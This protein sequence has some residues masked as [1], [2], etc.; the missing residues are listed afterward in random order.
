[1]KS[2]PKNLKQKF[3]QIQIKNSRIK[4]IKLIHFLLVSTL[5]IR[6]AFIHHV[7]ADQYIAYMEKKETKLVFKKA[8]P[9][10]SIY[11]RNQQ[12]LVVNTPITTI[13]YRYNPQIDINQM[14][15]TADLL[16]EL[17]D[18]DTQKLTNRDLDDIYRR[19]FELSD[20]IE[21]TT[22]QRESIPD[23]AKQAFMIFR[24]MSEAY[25]GGENTLK[26]D[27]TDHE[28]ARVTE[29]IDLL[30]GIDIVTSTQRDYPSVLGHHDLLGRL[31]KE[32]GLPTE[33]F[34]TYMLNNYAIN[35]RV[36]TSSLE[37]HYEELLR[38]HKSVHTQNDSHQG[39]ETLFEGYSGANLTLTIDAAFVNQVDEILERRMRS[40]KNNRPGA[41]YLNEGYVVVTNP[42]TGEILSLNGLVLEEDGTATKHPL[43]TMHNSFTMGSVIKGATMLT[44]YEH[45]VVNY[46]D[47]VHDKPMIFSDGSK[48]GSWSSLGLINDIDALRYSSNVYFMTQAIQLGGDVYYPRSHLNLDLA[49]FD[50]YRASFAQFGLGSPTGIDLPNEQ[51]GLRDSDRSVAKLLD[52]VIGQSDTYTTLQLAQYVS[53]V[54]NGGHRYALQLLKEASIPVSPYES[55]LVHSFEPKLLNTIDLPEDAFR[56]V[57]EGFRQALQMQGGTGNHVFNNASYNPA[58]KTG[59]AEEFV[60]D[61]DGKLIYTTHGHLIPVHHMTFIG[62][63]PADHPEIAVAVVFPQSELPMHKNQLVLEV[64]DDVFKAY[65]GWYQS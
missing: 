37:H 20:D 36:G 27:V 6:L 23:H 33:H 39:I 19:E 42:N 65:F 4:I 62:Y 56:R 35:D 18:V 61:A 44:G 49:V 9:R 17:I 28:I 8:K 54:A 45:G 55:I 52:F 46:G 34:Q 50:T 13:I 2:I 30:P 29:Q 3:T 1:M 58:G 38:G 43:G 5:F 15:A 22:Q 53:T 64:A 59:T 31:S 63:A 24:N 14:L 40:A 25:Y 7:H 47:V 32:G 10:G 21:I 16:A 60:R 57:H 48:K 26:F 51:S 41:K 11:D 12:E